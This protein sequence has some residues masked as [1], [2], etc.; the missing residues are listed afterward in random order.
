MTLLLR[1]HESCPFGTKRIVP[2]TMS[3]TLTLPPIFT[4][5]L[6]RLWSGSSV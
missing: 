5:G 3:A 2:G 6:V 4:Q 1:R